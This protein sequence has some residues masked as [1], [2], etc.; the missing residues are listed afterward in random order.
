MG[1]PCESAYS[2][3]W[4]FCLELRGTGNATGQIIAWSPRITHLPCLSG[5]VGAWVRMCPASAGRGSSAYRHGSSGYADVCLE[6]CSGGLLTFGMRC[7]CMRLLFG[8]LLVSSLTI[9]SSVQRRTCHLTIRGVTAR[10][11]EDSDRGGERWEGRMGADNI[12]TS[13]T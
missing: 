11:G 8:F 3:P 2:S 4:H 12:R 5:W 9:L 7:E 1:K 13:K 10:V 6:R